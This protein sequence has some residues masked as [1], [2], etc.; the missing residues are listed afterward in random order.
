MDTA[1]WERAEFVSK[2]RVGDFLVFRGLNR[3]ECHVVQRRGKQEIEIY[4][5]SEMLCPADTGDML[6]EF[7]SF[8]IGMIQDE[9][10]AFSLTLG[11]DGVYDEGGIL[12]KEENSSEKVHEVRYIVHRVV[13]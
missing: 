8:L 13:R 11:D 2:L 5:A 4:D 12:L 9:L 10:T 3:A 6:I 1:V 7:P